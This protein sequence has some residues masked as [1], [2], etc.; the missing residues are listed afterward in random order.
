MQHLSIPSIQNKYLIWPLQIKLTTIVASTHNDVYTIQHDWTINAVVNVFV[1]VGVVKA[2]SYLLIFQVGF[3]P[4]E[5]IA[6]RLSEP[7]NRMK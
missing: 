6:W 5:K 3:V 4:L 2:A 1:V 7:A